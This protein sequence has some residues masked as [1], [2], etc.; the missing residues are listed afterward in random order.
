MH[1][2]SRVKQCAASEEVEIDSEDELTLAGV[3]GEG[4]ITSEV[5]FE[6]DELKLTCVKEGGDRNEFIKE[7]NEDVSLKSLREL[8]DRGERGY[9][10]EYGLLVQ[11]C[12]DIAYGTVI[13][14]VV[15][16][17]RRSNIMRLAHDKLGHLGHKKVASTI[18][19]NLVWPLMNC[20]IK[21]YCESC[22][23]CQKVNMG[24]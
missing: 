23:L 8:A 3:E 11:R 2:G 9:Y 15:P 1:E 20:D 18:K 16:K 12:P 24:G 4:E 21:K 14:I 7:V 22:L 5:G 17:S 13:N 19:R 10:W 6:V